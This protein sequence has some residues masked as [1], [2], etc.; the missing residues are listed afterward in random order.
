MICPCCG[1]PLIEVRLDGIVI[2]RCETCS[3]IWFDFAELERVLNRDT[4]AIGKLLPRTERLE[5]PNLDMLPCPRCR[6]KLI[7]MRAE[8]ERMNYYTC[9][10]CYGRWLGGSA[11]KRVA[12]RSLAIRFERVFQQLL[13]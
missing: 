9:L 5:D 6:D 13:D 12:D 8:P 2:D 3:G 11:L 10:T 1:T 7:R 4:H